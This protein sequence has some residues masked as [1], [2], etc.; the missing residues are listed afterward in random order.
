LK[1]YGFGLN[2]NKSQILFRRQKG[3]CALCDLLFEHE[4]IMEV[5]H[6]IPR[7]KGGKNTYGNLRLV[8]GHCHDQ[9]Q[10]LDAK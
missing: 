10:V 3:R 6:I 7:A 9:K 5:D 4:E 1:N 8:H 2:S